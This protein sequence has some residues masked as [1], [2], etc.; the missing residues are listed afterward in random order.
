MLYSSLACLAGLAATAAARPGQDDAAAPKSEGRFKLPFTK[1]ATT[2]TNSKIASRAKTGDVPFNSLWSMPMQVGTPPQTLELLPDTGSGDFTIESDLL[3]ASLRGTG[4]IYSPGSSS[5]ARQLPGYTY[6]ECYGSGYC[7]SG[8]VYTDVCTLGDVTVTGVPIQVVNS[9]SSKGGDQ[10]GNVG[11]SFGTP[12]AAN[13]R[14]P[15]GFLW[16]IRSALDSGVFTV[17]YDDSTNSGE[18]EFGYVDP[19]KFT[20]AMA[21]APLDVSSSSGGE[22]ITEF[23]GFIVNGTFIIYSWPVILDT[24]TGGS[25]VPRTLA[26]YYFSQVPGSTWNSAWNQ[27][28]YPCSESLPDLTIGIGAVTKF[29][30][31]G[32]GLVAFSL[33]GTNCLSKLGVSN[34]SPYFF[35]Q[36]LMEELFIVFDF[37]NAQIGFGEKPKSGSPPGTGITSGASAPSSSGSS[38]VCSASG[39]KGTC[40][41][42]P[43]PNFACKNLAGSNVNYNVEA[44]GPDEGSCTLYSD[45]ICETPISS[46][47]GVKNPGNS[48][49]NNNVGS[50]MCT[51]PAIS[52]SG[53]GTIYLCSAQ[54]WGG[55]CNNY[56]WSSYGCQTLDEAH[57]KTVGSAGPNVGSCMFYVDAHCGYPASSTP[58]QNPGT[59]TL[60][61]GNRV[62]SFMCI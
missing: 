39:F 16:S 50:F 47:Q 33:D 21:Y 56:N 53:S 7:D 60:S 30:L 48:N 6:S 20:G 52:A 28:Q 19:S 44:F 49:I 26:D 36:N 12:Q 4:P 10:T 11:L 17:A 5:T 1:R 54:N 13:P 55:T 62:G 58:L 35:A 59:G 43:W 29:T 8:I 61:Y 3:A 51:N 14:G 42:I 9:A 24:G 34:S 2:T 57:M 31:P 38:Y 40:Q 46:L 15:S 37:D 45:S 41:N 22:W 18:F 32:S 23:S 25:G 27:Y